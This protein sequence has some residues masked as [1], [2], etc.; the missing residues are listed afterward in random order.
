MTILFRECRTE[1]AKAVRRAT[2][3]NDF[4]DKT[5]ATMPPLVM[6]A[7]CTMATS[8]NLVMEIYQL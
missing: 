2:G 5:I 1:H 8:D 6:P 3:T 7:L 4:R